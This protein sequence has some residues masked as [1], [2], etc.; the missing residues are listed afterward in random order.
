VICDAAVEQVLT[1]HVRYLEE[2]GGDKVDTLEQLE[3]DVHVVW[4]LTA[5]LNL[6][7][8]R[9]SLMLPLQQQALQTHNHGWRRGVVVSSIRHMN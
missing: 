7:L 5:L 1:G 6:L 3:V 9:G 2:H 8:L 4:H